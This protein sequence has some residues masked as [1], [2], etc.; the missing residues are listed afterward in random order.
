M[1]REDVLAMVEARQVGVA[2]IASANKLV[3]RSRVGDRD[4]VGGANG[5]GN[6]DGAKY[7]GK[8]RGRAV[9][10]NTGEDVTIAS[11]ATEIDEARR[12]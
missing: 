8:C 1:E 3:L 11:T 2:E 12:L 9:A 10:G 6:I 7:N 5:D 4:V